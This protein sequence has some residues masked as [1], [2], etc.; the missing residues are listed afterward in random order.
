MALNRSLFHATRDHIAPE[1]LIWG[2]VMR[3]G[4]ISVETFWDYDLEREARALALFLHNILPLGDA[5]IGL[6]AGTHLHAEREEYYR[7][8]DFAEWLSL[9]RAAFPWDATFAA[10]GHLAAKV[11]LP[12]SALVDGAKRIVRD[13]SFR[14]VWGRLSLVTLRIA[15]E[16][17]A[18]VSRRRHRTTRAHLKRLCERAARGRRWDRLQ[19]AHVPA[20]EARR[21]ALEGNIA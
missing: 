12:G 15:A 11:N 7:T 5:D 1:M 3:A 9:Y 19:R 13:K 6:S 18:I 4:G 21:V 2:P 20:R 8:L 10:R 16:M 14:H 17:L